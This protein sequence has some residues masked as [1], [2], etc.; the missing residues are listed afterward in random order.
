MFNI[1][2]QRATNPNDMDK[3]INQKEM[4]LNLN[5]IEEVLSKGNLDIWVAWGTLITKRPYLKQCLKDIVLIANKYNCKFYSIGA[6]SKQGH[7]HHPLYLKKDL[8]L[9]KFDM[10]NYLILSPF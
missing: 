3:T 6:I 2:P 9:E 1:Y 8:K 7:P 5:K 10:D 4:Q